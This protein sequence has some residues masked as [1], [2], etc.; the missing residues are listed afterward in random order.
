MLFSKE[1]YAKLYSSSPEHSYGAP[2]KMVE[3]IPSLLASGSILDLGA[4]DG[5][6]SIF[7]AEKGFNVRATDISEA[8]LS[9]L[10]RIAREKGVSVTT[11]L[12]DLATWQMSANYDVVIAVQIFQHLQTS[13]ALRLLEEVKHHTS[14][15]GI[16]LIS[17][18]TANGDRYDMDRKLD[19]EA[20]YPADNWLKVYYADWTVIDHVSHRS[21]LNGPRNDDGSAKT[22][23]VERILVQKPDK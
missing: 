10:Q 21:E 7:L 19:P 13:D 12:A 5:R 14:P 8:A 22:S 11:E 18:F 1:I 17:L 23:V 4:G 6:H 15:G 3:Q 2:G 9:K 20:F 16:N